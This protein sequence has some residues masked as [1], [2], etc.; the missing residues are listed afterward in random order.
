VSVRYPIPE[1]ITETATHSQEL[2]VDGQQFLG[3][4][5]IEGVEVAFGVPD[6]E[7][8][9]TQASGSE[10]GWET[11]DGSGFLE[12]FYFDQ[13]SRIDPVEYLLLAHL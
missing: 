6:C 1:S 12:E 13:R 11:A 8:A 3:G 2:G 9:Q 5:A 10:V 7:Q 4:V